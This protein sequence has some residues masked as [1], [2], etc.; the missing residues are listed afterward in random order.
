MKVSLIRHTTVELDG[1]RTCYG[2]TDVE[3]SSNFRVEAEELKKSIAH[4]TPDAVFSSPLKRARKLADHVGFTPIVEDDRLKEL[5]FG[6]LELREWSE[7]LSNV[8]VEQFFEYHIVHP[9]PKGESLLEQQ[10][11]V[12]AFFDEKKALGLQHIMVFCHG[13][14]INCLR[15]IIS[16]QPLRET[17]TAMAPF[18]TH[19]PLEY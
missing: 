19:I 16:D 8:D 1:S 11:R 6:E 2:Q 14:V 10:R 5:N 15:S 18:A 3:V 7:I 17:F 12:K 4:L 13:G 9:F